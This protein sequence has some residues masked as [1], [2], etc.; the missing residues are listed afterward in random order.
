M[1][2]LT[3]NK[4]CFTKESRATCKFD[5]GDNKSASPPRAGHKDKRSEYKGK[6]SDT[7]YKDKGDKKKSYYE[8][9]SKSN[10]PSSSHVDGESLTAVNQPAW[11]N[12]PKGP[13]VMWQSLEEGEEPSVSYSAVTVNQTS[14]SSSVIQPVLRSRVVTEEDYESEQS[15]TESED[16]EDDQPIS[17]KYKTSKKHR[18]GKRKPRADKADRPFDSVPPDEEREPVR[19]IPEV[20]QYIVEIL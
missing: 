2:C 16:G 20:D 19:S 14:S 9:P 17:V 6:K 11:T 18:R 12:E 4:E 15:A 13:R 7:E 10:K 5:L 8:K 1:K 3:H